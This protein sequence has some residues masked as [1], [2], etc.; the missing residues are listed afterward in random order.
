MLIGHCTLDFSATVTGISQF[1]RWKYSI[2]L[3][4]FD[5]NLFQVDC[6]PA[7]TRSTAARYC[8]DVF[9]EMV[10]DRQF[11]AAANRAT[12]HIKDMALTD[13]GD[14]IGVATMIDKFGATAAHGP[15]EGPIAIESEEVDEPV[16]LIA[17]AFRFLATD[18]LA[19]ILDDFAAGG[20]V[21]GSI[22]APAVD[23]RGADGEAESGIFGIDGGHVIRG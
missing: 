12:T 19:A 17:A 23:F 21:L 14:D 2:C 8:F 13:F 3:R 20:N 15:V 10:I 4:C 22:N 5:L 11:L 6:A 9:S 16:L 18:A 1:F 7:R